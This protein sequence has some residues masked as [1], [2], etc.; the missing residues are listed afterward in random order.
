MKTEHDN[1][2][3]D[4]KSPQPNTE[5]RKL[6][7]EEELAKLR[8]ENASLKADNEKLRKTCEEQEQAIASGNS[9]VIKLRQTIARLNAALLKA[10]E[11]MS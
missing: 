6:T 8:E 1:P 4:Q 2:K 11:R 7:P 9:L 10:V 3:G 5:P